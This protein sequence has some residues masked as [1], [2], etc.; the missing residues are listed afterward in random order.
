MNHALLRITLLIVITLSQAIAVS[1]QTNQ[2]TE[3]SLSPEE[4]E[5]INARKEN[6]KAQA[7][8]Y[9]KLTDPTPTPSPKS[10][11]QI[12][13]GNPTSVVGVI[14]V[15]IA[16]LFTAMVG[17]L[18]LYVNNRSA[19]ISHTDTQFYEALKL[20]GDK[21]SSMRSSAAGILGRMSNIKRFEFDI[22]KPV[23]SLIRKRPYHGI[24]HNQLIIGF[25]SEKDVFTLLQ[26]RRAIYQIVYNNP[27]GLATMIIN[28]NSRLK[29]EVIKALADFLIAN[30]VTAAETIDEELWKKVPQNQYKHEVLK[31]L[32]NYDNSFSEAFAGML[33]SYAVISN[34]E[35][36]KKKNLFTTYQNF[37]LVTYRLRL[38]TQ[39]YC[40]ILKKAPSLGRHSRN[41]PLF[42]VGADLIGAP[43]ARADLQKAFLSGAK[44][45][46]ANLKNAKMQGAW[47]DGA[48]LTDARLADVQVDDKTS[49]R[50]VEWWKA[51]YFINK[52]NK[53]I[54]SKLLGFLYQHHKIAL[55]KELN[56][57]HPSVQRFI[58]TT[59]EASSPPSA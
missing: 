26:I 13:A 41:H 10:L 24:A 15:I 14:G 11:R 2:T 3:R 45:Q 53:S 42:L 1:P 56:K 16:A 38:I 18:T 32:V 39:I 49:M 31:Y 48:D 47:L 40:D 5:L 17:L 52:R 4:R 27:S 22:R 57:L 58:Q 34:D 19:I 21:N 7:A 51:N 54:D 50:N 35:P 59:S 33:L 44:L 43:L 28:A 36:K 6:E 9:T 37:T 55:P 46:N 29:M 30:G 23:S 12:L 25:I 8:Y 20:F